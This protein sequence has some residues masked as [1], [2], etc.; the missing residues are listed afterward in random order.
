MDKTTLYIIIGASVVLFLVLVFTFIRLSGRRKAKK[1]QES[2]DKVK[3]ESA[4]EEEVQP[5]TYSAD[6]VGQNVSEDEIFGDDYTVSEGGGFFKQSKEE[7]DE[8]LS[9]DSIFQEFESKEEDDD[10]PRM[11]RR[12][13][14]RQIQRER[15]NRD[16]E[17]EEFLNE[18]AFSRKVFDKPLLDKIKK[19]PPEIKSIIMGNVFDK[20]ND[21]K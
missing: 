7:D 6:E 5:I 19:L 9:E 15:E 11:P 13:N 2:L 16:A 8:D 4:P 21:D 10:M 20:F 1:L 17:F 18:H 3:K 12:L 14:S